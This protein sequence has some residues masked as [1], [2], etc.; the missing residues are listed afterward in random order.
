MNTL[1]VRLVAWCGAHPRIAALAFG[2][3][4]ATGFQPLGLWPLALAAMAC[5]VALLAH[6]P[7]LRR[8][9][10]LGWLFGFAH[11]TLGN[12]WIAAAFTHQ[13]NMP[14]VLGWGAVP[15]LA[16]YLAA[17]PAL[18][19]LGARAIAGRGLSPALVL[20]LAGCWPMA[21]LLRATVFTGYAWNP[22]AM[23]LL[24]PLDRPGLAAIAPF[25]GTYA[26]SGVAVLI[27]GGL[28]LMLARRRWSALA[29]VAVLIGAGMYWPAP[30]TR[31]GAVRYTL[32]Q[33]NL[34]QAV[35]HDSVFYEGNFAKLAG[36]SLPRGDGDDGARLVLWPESGMSDYLR[37]GY[38][39]RFYD[40]M[41]AFGDPEASRRRIGRVIGPDSLLLTGAV[42]LEISRGYAVGAY[43]SVTA[44]DG[45]G[46]IRGGYSKAHLVP[47]GEY[48]PMREILE[49]IGLSRLVPGAIDFLPGP[50]PRTLPL[51]VHGN[52][53]IQICY[54]IIF[55]GQVADRAHR[56]DY[57]FN[58]SN[59]GWFGT[60]GPPQHLAQARMRAVEEGL[61]VLR[62]T[63]TGI[64]AVIDPHGR[65]VQ[66]LAS[67]RAGRMDG[68]V[69]AALPPTPFAM[70][71]NMLC[72]F[73][74]VV[75]LASAFVAL[76]QSGR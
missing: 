60:F 69:P 67:N 47:Y 16:L 70:L 3:L 44:I 52:A 40:R 31:E 37:P 48:L 15:L 65:V 12:N 7:D 30:A 22:F 45:A 11:F 27:A 54:E 10:V 33:P 26:L 18:A 25:T 61:P 76:R 73:W 64:S 42:D 21:E 8:A 36:L 35:L 56:P 57:I 66:H 6:A 5:F 50:G 9:A 49:P 75:F 68:V 53:G 17:Y 13:A 20:A 63:T 41:T 34:P 24:G 14:A 43:N 39:Q 29:L 32:V 71:G 4:S 19:A 2:L 72:L 51:G 28:A 23:V 46:A 59:D 58:P 38:P 55:S 74:S 62:S 1:P